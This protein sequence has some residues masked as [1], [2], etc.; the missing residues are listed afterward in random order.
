[1]VTPDGTFLFFSRLRG[2]SR[3]EATAGDVYWVDATTLEQIKR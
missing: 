2:A 1:M 3:T